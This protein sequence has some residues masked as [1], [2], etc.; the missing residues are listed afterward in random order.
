MREI[1]LLLLV[2]SYNLMTLAGGVESPH[3]STAATPGIELTNAPT[4]VETAQSLNPLIQTSLYVSGAAV[5][6]AGM[7]HFDQQIYTTLYGWRRHSAQ[8]SSISPAITTLGTGT[9]SVGLFGSYLSYGIFTNDK[10]STQIGKIGLE[11]FLASG[12]GVQIMK[13]LFGREQPNVATQP[14]GK[15]NGPLSYFRRNNLRTR[16]IASFDAFPSGHTTTAFAAATTISDAY[17]EPWISYI[18]YSFASGIAISRVMERMHWMSDCFVG[19]LIGYFSTRMVE[20]FNSLPPNLSIG[21]A[22]FHHTYGVK[23][24]IVM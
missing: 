23:L 18:S 2:L 22:E 17:D 8:L 4:V 24:S 12:L 16:G 9:I 11:S 7:I 19:G 10:K 13:Y 1:K 14:G 20:K 15:W 6:T 21:P 3:D 5:I